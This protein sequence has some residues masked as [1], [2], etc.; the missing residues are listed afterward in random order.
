MAFGLWQLSHRLP[1]Y[2]SLP[3]KLYTGVLCVSQDELRW[4]ISLGLCP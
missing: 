3:R 4:E 2:I 1:Q